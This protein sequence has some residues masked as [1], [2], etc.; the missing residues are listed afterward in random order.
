M[1]TAYNTV[2]PPHQEYSRQY[3]LF[4]G[5]PADHKTSMPWYTVDISTSASRDTENK[6]DF[7]SE[8]TADTTSSKPGESKQ[9]SLHARPYSRQYGLQTMETADNVLPPHREIQQTI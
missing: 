3:G 8:D 6:R 9:Y 7:S 4:T 2:W 5:E 1:D